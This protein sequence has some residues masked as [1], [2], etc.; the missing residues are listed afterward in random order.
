MDSI[1]HILVVGKCEPKVQV[2]V[3]K[4]KG[5]CEGVRMIGADSKLDMRPSVTHSG[6]PWPGLD[7]DPAPWHMLPGVGG[8]V[9]RAASY[10]KVWHHVSYLALSST[11]NY[12]DLCI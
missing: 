4:G 5:S 8:M 9:W 1:K 11:A 10:A 6:A 7:T 2:P 12:C 3:R